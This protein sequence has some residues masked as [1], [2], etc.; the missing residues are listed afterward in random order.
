[1]FVKIRINSLP[2]GYH[3]LPMPAKSVAGYTITQNGGSERV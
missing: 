2:S 1:M 3:G